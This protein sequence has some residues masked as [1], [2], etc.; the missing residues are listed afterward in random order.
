MADTTD[1][2]SITPDVRP[3]VEQLNRFANTPEVMTAL[4]RAQADALTK[5]RADPSAR[6]AFVS[7]DP[8][9]FSRSPPEA[10]GSIRVAV[11]RDPTGEGEERHANSTQYLFAFDGPL[12][13]HVQTSGGWRQDR[14]GY[15]DGLGDETATALEDR[16]HVVPAATWHRSL[17]PGTHEWS[18][19][20]FH[21]ARQ[22]SDEYR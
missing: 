7:V 9:G 14:Y 1:N 22:V 17:A 13:T 16:W 10:L 12:E 8:T 3:V 4:R 19:V 11:I 5:L 21:S 15:G 6:A 2:A 20:A 18:V